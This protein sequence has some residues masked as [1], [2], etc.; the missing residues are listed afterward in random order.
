VCCLLRAPQTLTDIIAHQE[1]AAALM[2]GHALHGNAPANQAAAAE[3]QQH[4]QHHW[5]SGV[6]ATQPAAP[7][8]P[9]GADAATQQQQQ[10][11]AQAS[12]I[13][14]IARLLQTATPGTLARVRAMSSN[15][16]SQE[17]LRL[18]MQL[19][20]VLERLAKSAQQTGAF[21]FQASASAP[22]RAEDE[23]ALIQLVDGGVQLLLL[24][25][26]LN[27]MPLM[28]A[29]LAAQASEDLS[30]GKAG[31]HGAALSPDGTD[32]AAGAAA[33]V[34]V[35]A[36]A[37]D[38]WQPPSQCT[39]W[40]R[41]LLTLSHPLHEE[42]LQR[43][44][45]L[46][47][48]VARWTRTAADTGLALTTRVEV[49]SL[50]L[51]SDAS[52]ACAAPYGPNKRHG[53]KL[54]AAAATFVRTVLHSSDSG[55]DSSGD[56]SDT[57]TSRGSL[58]FDNEVGSSSAGATPTA[59]AVA[60]V[61]AA[62]AQAQGEEDLSP[63]RLSTELGRHVVLRHTHLVLLD[64]VALNTL[65]QLQVRGTN[66]LWHTHARTHCVHGQQHHCC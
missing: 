24:G 48:E 8:V 2:Q 4:H 33:P 50:L 66:A 34:G 22:T 31:A 41:V 13:S 42:Q 40:E 53:K 25:M 32:P 1:L 20:M 16:W 43:L 5:L 39:E 26:L 64:M 14:Y 18:Y 56:D 11:Q 12:Y 61:A 65:S 45:A 7:F 29:A 28:S 51:A 30:G 6:S 60:A 27:P 37:A 47:A 35:G 55:N 15:D 38:G 62:A 23:A 46:D 21:F 59:A 9:S 17:H 54:A 63:G 52:I 19:V 44:R 57:N 36:E 49:S 58:R 3:Q 10:A